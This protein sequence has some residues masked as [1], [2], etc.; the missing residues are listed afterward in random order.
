MV[1]VR[2]IH[3]YQ[4]FA[5]NITILLNKKKKTLS[6][7]KFLL[8]I[9]LEEISTIPLISSKNDFQMVQYL[10]SRMDWEVEVDTVPAEFLLLRRLASRG[11]VATAFSS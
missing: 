8:L 7:R 11:G 6:H 9:S 10:L 5:A 3:Q 1:E 4:G 2:I